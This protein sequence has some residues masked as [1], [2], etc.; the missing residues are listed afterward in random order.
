MRFRCGG[1][2]LSRGAKRRTTQKKAESFTN[3]G[4]ALMPC[5][6][7][8]FHEYYVNGQEENAY[9]SPN[10]NDRSTTE[11]YISMAI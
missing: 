9:T 7:N 3:D 5:K 8:F 10:S 2:P 6:D 11:L 1:R 4:Q